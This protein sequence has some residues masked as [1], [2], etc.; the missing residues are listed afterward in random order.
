MSKMIIVEGNS[1]D[2]DNVRV[3]M[4]KG[5]KGDPGDLNP[6]NIVDNL[7][8]TATD[9]A[10]S[11]KQGKVLKSLIDQK[12]YY[13]DTVALM[14]AGNLSSG[15]Y[16]ITK[17]YYSANDGG[18]ANYYITSSSS[19]TD[20]QEELNNGLYATL[21]VKNEINVAQLGLYGDGIHDDSDRL[22]DTLSKIPSNTNVNFTIN[23]TY[24]IS[25]PIYIPHFVCLNGN[26]CNISVVGDT[27]NNNNYLFNYPSDRVI[28]NNDTRNFNYSTYF[29]N[30]NIINNANDVKNVISV[31]GEM[32]ISNIY[33]YGFNKTVNL[34]NRY[35]DCISI[36]DI[37]SFNKSGND[38]VI[39]VGFLGDGIKISRVHL[40][41]AEY[42]GTLNNTRII[43][44]HNAI[45]LDTLINGNIYLENS[46]VNINNI[47]LET[48]H[49]FIKNASVN[50]DNGYIIKH[51][52]VYPLE[53]KGV[54]TYVKLS[55]IMVIYQT[56]FVDYSEDDCIDIYTDFNTHLTLENCYKNLTNSYDIDYK[57]LSGLTSNN[58]DFNKNMVINSLSSVKCE[59]TYES[60]LK[61][62]IRS[63]NQ[64]P[65]IDAL[66]KT[67]NVTWKKP[68]GTYYYYPITLFDATRLVG[69]NLGTDEKNITVTNNEQ[70]VNM[71]IGYKPSANIRMY[72]GTS[73]GAYTEYADVGPVGQQITDNGDVLNGNKWVSRTSGGADTVLNAQSFEYIGLW[74]RNV[75]V[76]AG[77]I[78]S[79]GTWTKGDV[80]INNNPSIG[81]VYGWVCTADGT[82]GTWKSFGSID[83]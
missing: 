8:S 80:I 77:S 35:N 11:A 20:Y 29:K 17:G 78:P 56:S 23:K 51:N 53:I 71:P 42:T 5:E 68:S 64:Y 63:N 15:D 3:L 1:N 65:Y 72:R 55:N 39:E 31:D 82:P 19:A 45:R 30:F 2:K 4:V 47:H 62:Q 49:V 40:Y 24:K 38:Y 69:S 13:F 9:K 32:N 26:S 57:S 52:N 33:T 76:Y 27:L 37:N 12:P 6:E 14:K 34:V 58:S 16:V 28:P 61:A 73:T 43:G 75:K 83:S 67:G 21:I 60:T 22:N 59:E 74:H 54:N 10:L 41:Q 66:Y 46:N 18:G 7:N 36:S 44:G 50:I 48:G 70:G 79:V 25:K 81:G